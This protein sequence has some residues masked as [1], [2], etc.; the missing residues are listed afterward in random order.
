MV[1]SQG[2]K[3]VWHACRSPRAG[4]LRSS[5]VGTKMRIKQPTQRPG[6]DRERLERENEI[7]KVTKRLEIT[8]IV[9]TY[10]KSGGGDSMEQ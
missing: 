8:F 10:S 1:G 5:K 7:Y 6:L 9:I 3:G 4:W 2:K